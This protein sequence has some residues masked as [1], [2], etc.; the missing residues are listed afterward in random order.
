MSDFYRHR[1]ARYAVPAAFLAFQD[2][3][4]RTSP[5]ASAK[6]I[7]FFAALFRA[8][9]DAVTQAAATMA[10]LPGIDAAFI[11]AVMRHV[12]T[13]AARTV[14]DRLGVSVRRSQSRPLIRACQHAAA[15]PVVAVEEWP[16]PYDH[17]DALAPWWSPT[18]PGGS[19]TPWP[20]EVS[21]LFAPARDSM[22]LHDWLL[23]SSTAV[24]EALWGTFYATGDAKYIRRIADIASD[25]AHDGSAA[26]GAV[27]LLLDLRAPMPPALAGP[28]DSPEATARAVRAQTARVAIWSLIHHTRRHTAVT[29]TLAAEVSD[30][31]PWLVDTDAHGSAAAAEPSAAVA[32]AALRRLDVFP[33]VLHL[34]A[35]SRLDSMIA[36]AAGARAGA[37]RGGAGGGAAPGGDAPP[38]S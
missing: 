22:T 13:P 26:D 15:V 3:P 27:G 28:G 1:E 6:L 36:S 35:R 31:A 21:G 19:P 5:V 38:S 12:G 20:W 8:H 24:V 17:V 32:G 11:L 7:A 16:M 30:L 25:W 18:P 29:K 37:A 2:A 9:P 10:M 14:A 4:S 23:V 33:A 34:A